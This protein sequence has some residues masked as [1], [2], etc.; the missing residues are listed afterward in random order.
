MKTE[1]RKVAEFRKRLDVGTASWA[2][3]IPAIKR[4][5]LELTAEQQQLLK[6]ATKQDVPSLTLVLQSNQLPPNGHAL[7]C[8]QVQGSPKPRS[9]SKK[10]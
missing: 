4:I 9:R 7:A 10:E 2:I 6:R 1:A 5:T 3:D 8:L